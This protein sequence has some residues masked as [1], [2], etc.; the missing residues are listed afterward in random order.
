MNISEQLKRDEGVVKHAYRDHLGYL[1]IGIGFLIDERKGGR[2]PDEVMEFWL[3]YEIEKR[4]VALSKAIPFFDDLDEARQGALVNMAYQLGVNGVLAFKK[5]LHS[6]QRG[7]YDIAAKEAL[8][9]RWATQTP[10]RAKRIAKQIE[11]GEWQ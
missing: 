6:M 5:M 3:G 10:E 4:R 11:T 7:D 1:T 2:M 8:D 9:S